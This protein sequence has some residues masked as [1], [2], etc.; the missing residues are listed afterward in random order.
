M[1]NGAGGEEDVTSLSYNLRRTLPCA[2]QRL[3]EILAKVISGELTIER[4]L[5][6][7]TRRADA[8]SALS[9]YPD[10]AEVQEYALRIEELCGEIESY[11][12]SDSD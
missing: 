2:E 12:T 3:R 7:I 1:M 10:S 4:R 5:A 6:M 8:R 9:R 11:F